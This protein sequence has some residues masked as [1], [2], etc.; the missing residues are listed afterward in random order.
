MTHEANQSVLRHRAAIHDLSV[1]LERAEACFASR[2]SG[3]EAAKKALASLWQQALKEN[4][5]AAYAAFVSAAKEVA[6]GSKGVITPEQA[7]ALGKHL[8]LVKAP[9]GKAR[10]AVL[11]KLSQDM[12]PFGNSFNE[13]S[14]CHESC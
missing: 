7:E 13:H 5:V 2:C 10:R 1:S 3:K 12:Q 8:A 11:H 9:S 6:G 14:T 4:S